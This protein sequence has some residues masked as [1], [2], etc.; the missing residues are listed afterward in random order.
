M[1]DNTSITSIITQ[2][3]WSAVRRLDVRT[4]TRNLV[5]KQQASAE[6]D[7]RRWATHEL[8]E[9]ARWHEVHDKAQEVGRL[10]RIFEVDHEWV[11]ERG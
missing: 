2:Q 6:G 5:S 4:Y 8:R 9:V 11:R 7:K 3:V 1:Y 10:E